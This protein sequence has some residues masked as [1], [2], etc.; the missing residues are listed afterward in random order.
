MKKHLH[1]DEEEHDEHHEDHEIV[2]DEQEDK[3][4]HEDKISEVDVATNPKDHLT[5]T[6][7]SVAGGN[8]CER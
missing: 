2:E 3:L 1:L 5:T 4:M 7:I 6:P 8:G